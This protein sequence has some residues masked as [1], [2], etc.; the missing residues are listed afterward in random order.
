[1]RS[2]YYWI[3]KILQRVRNEDDPAF[4]ALLTMTYLNCWHILILIRVLVKEYG[5]IIYKNDVISLGIF[6]S[7]L[8]LVVNY[9]LVYK[10]RSEFVIIMKNSTPLN[11]RRSKVFSFIY[12]VIS[13]LSMVGVLFFY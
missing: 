12:L 9:F 4:G 2:I 3:Y 13:I 7:L 10:K 6:L 11:L 8:I 5:L 1:M